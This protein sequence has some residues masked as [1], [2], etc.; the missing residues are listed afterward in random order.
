MQDYVNA[1]Y[2]DSL[3]ISNYEGVCYSIFFALKYDCEINS[4]ECQELINI[5]DCLV[6]LFAWLY[7]RKRPGS[8]IQMLEAEAL[9]LRDVNVG[10]YWLFVYEVLNESYLPVGDWQNMKKAGISFIVEEI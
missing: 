7:Y 2:R 5:G 10:R 3:R 6:L 8:E 4:I 1:L 9:R